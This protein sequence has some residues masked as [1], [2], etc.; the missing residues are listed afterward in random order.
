MVAAGSCCVTLKLREELSY[1][2]KVSM[3]YLVSDKVGHVILMGV[4]HY[5]IAPISYRITV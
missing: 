3:G 5:W 1:I 4:F 2:I